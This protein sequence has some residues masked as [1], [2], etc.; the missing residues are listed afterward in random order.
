MN[1]FTVMLNMVIITQGISSVPVHGNDIDVTKLSM[2]IARAIKDEAKQEVSAAV[3]M[4]DGQEDVA[5]PEMTDVAPKKEN[6]AEIEEISDVTVDEDVNDI[7]SGVVNIEPEISKIGTP[8]AD[9][10]ESSVVDSPSNHISNL[11]NEFVG[12]QNDASNLDEQNDETWFG[13]NPWLLQGTNVCFGARDSKYGKFELQQEGMM[14]GIKIVHKGGYVTCNNN[15]KSNWGCTPGHVHLSVYITDT[16]NQKIL[17]KHVTE[18]GSSKAWFV[19]PGYNSKSPELVFTDMCSPMYAH[20]GQELR[21]W[22]GE[23]LVGHTESDNGGKS[24][25][26]VYARFA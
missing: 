16:A 9:D 24:C 8:E 14:T 20:K 13:G 4:N 18:V 21:L 10:V 1:L 19:L 7:P 22:Y 6:V 17:P 5:G 23:D 12:K 25:A 11:A 26:D 15:A 3:T 2:A